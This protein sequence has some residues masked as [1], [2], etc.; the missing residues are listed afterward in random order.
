MKMKIIMTRTKTKNNNSSGWVDSFRWLLIPISAVVLALALN[1]FVILSAIVPSASMADTI[2]ENSFVISSRLAYLSHSPERGDVV[3]FSHPEIDERYVIKRV[4]GLPGDTVSL[5]NGRV[6]INSSAEPL[7]EEYVKEFSQDDFA[8]IVIPQGS[9]FVLGDNREES[10][11]SRFMDDPFVKVEN[12]YA[13]A[14]Y[15]IYPSF[16]N[17]K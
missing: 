13:K 1:N 9:Y 16:K 5:K 8:E 7:A 11:D 4:I 17:L 12:I 15:V 10:F 3:I 2:A 6:Y 14:E